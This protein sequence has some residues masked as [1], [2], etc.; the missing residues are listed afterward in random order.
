LISQASHGG[1]ELVQPL[2]VSRLTGQ[3]REQGPAGTAWARTAAPGLDDVSEQGLYYGKV[4]SSASET[5][6]VTGL[7][8]T[9]YGAALPPGH[10]CGRRVR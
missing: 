8:G 5:A 2:I 10:R 1:D 7:D 9:R 4:T 6:L 3:V